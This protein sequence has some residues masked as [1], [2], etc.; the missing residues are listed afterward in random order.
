MECVLWSVYYGVCTME[1]VL[2]SVYYGVCTMECVLW[3]VYYGV[4]TAGTAPV[5]RNGGW[6][7]KL[8]ECG[9]LDW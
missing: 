1:C 2:W 9:V 5:A 3:S 7:Q 8:F 4:C 6:D